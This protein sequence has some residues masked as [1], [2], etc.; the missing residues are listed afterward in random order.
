MSTGS[1]Y[2]AHLVWSGPSSELSLIEIDTD[3]VTFLSSSEDVPKLLA[4]NFDA[5]TLTVSSTE[6]ACV[7]T[8]ENNKYILVVVEKDNHTGLFFNGEE[9]RLVKIPFVDLEEIL[10]ITNMSWDLAIPGRFVACASIS[11]NIVSPAIVVLCYQSG[12]YEICQTVIPVG[13]FVCI[14]I[15]QCPL[16]PNRMVVFGKVDKD[17]LIKV[18]LLERGS[19][20]DSWTMSLTG[21]VPP[22][23][24]NSA[25]Y[26]SF[27]FAT[28]G[29]GDRVAIGD[30]TVSDCSG[31]VY[32]FTLSIPS[33]SD[34]TFERELD[35][36][37]AGFGSGLA[38]N[39]DQLLVAGKAKF[40]ILDRNY[41][42]MQSPINLAST[43]GSLK[44]TLSSMPITFDGNTTRCLVNMT[45]VKTTRIVASS[46]CL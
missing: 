22:P 46:L 38:F 32:T 1:Q 23:S 30:P 16:N 6:L 37:S 5:K 14:A 35:S 34:Y 18:Y 31:K 42:E 15:L 25:T 7:A 13:T 10:C 41:N 20:D 28:D 21:G 12:T 36:M 8:N 24:V 3:M 11:S 4:L 2:D 17:S 39:G 33:S 27:S 26:G 19:A 45:D 9:T 43:L 44:G 29:Y 40:H